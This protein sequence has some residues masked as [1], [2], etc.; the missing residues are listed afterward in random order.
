MQ[1][2]LEACSQEVEES[3]QSTNVSVYTD[4]KE[5]AVTR[6]VKFLCQGL[7]CN[8]S[9]DPHYLLPLPGQTCEI[10]IRCERSPVYRKLTHDEAYWFPRIIEGEI[11]HSHNSFMY[12][13]CS[14]ITARRLKTL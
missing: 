3:L 1:G 13:N 7:E 2:L 5:M 11:I 6:E 12:Y 10:D 14:T 8:S 4:V 9:S